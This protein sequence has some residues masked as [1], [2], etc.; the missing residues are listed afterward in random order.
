MTR[1]GA[2]SAVLLLLLSCG[3]LVLTVWAMGVGASEISMSRVAQ[4]LWNPSGERADIVVLQVRL[5]RVLA[6][7]TAGAAL[8][9]AGAIM[10]AMTG[11]PLA[12]PGLL[13]VNAGAAFAVVCALSF[14]DITGMSHLIW[15][16][17][18]GAAGAAALV[19]AL[20]AGPNPVRLVLA[21]VVVTSFLGAVTMAILMLD[22]QALDTVRFWTAGSLKGR[23]LEDV[24]SVLPYLL[25]SLV[26]ALLFAGQFT[27]MSLGSTVARG[28]GQNLALWRGLAALVVVGLAGS[29]V[30]M[31]GP[32]GFVGLVVP[33]MV[34]M[35]TGAEYRRIL[36]YCLIGGAVLTLA[37]DT[38]P[39]ALWG[40][41]VPAGITLAFLGAPFFIWLARSHGALRS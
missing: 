38:L 16:A 29:A 15:A 7:V 32:L 22:V 34:R 36:P 12:E 19:Y 31:A 25:G 40:R 27:A 41:D 20:G 33:H 35:R 3:L 4:A 1:P 8:A 30:A 37:S 26:L 21:G 24:A 10:Q 9:V 6:G 2:A 5:P 28:L 14:L 18:T 23:Q 39:R 17:F 11:N 13:G